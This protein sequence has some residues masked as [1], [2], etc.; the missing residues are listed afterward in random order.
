MT[1]SSSNTRELNIGQ[2]IRLARQVPGLAPLE[3]GM[4]GPQWLAA[5]EFGRSQ[6][7]LIIDRLST[8]QYLVRQVELYTTTVSAAGDGGAA[9]PIA[10]PGDTVDVVGTIMY[11]PSGQTAESTI[12]PVAREEWHGT[13][14]KSRTGTP[15]RYYLHRAG[16]VLL[17]LLPVPDVAGATLRIQRQ[18]LLADSGDGN[19]TPDIERY[20]ADYLQ[21]ELAFRYAVGTLPMD[22]VSTLRAEANR[23]LVEAK[24]KARPQLSTQAELGHMTGW[25]WR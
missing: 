1:I 19:A 16:S 2:I 12:Y 24:S 11:Q 17:Y 7:E 22:R 23:A 25:H 13:I 9:A 21:W 10:L 8:D 6:L 4:E 20:W 14:D 3:S 5:A 18:K 15:S